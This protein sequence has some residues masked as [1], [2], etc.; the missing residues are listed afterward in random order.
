MFLIYPLVLVLSK[1]LG[2]KYKPDVPQM[3]APAPAAANQQ[4]MVTVSHTVTN[5]GANA[6][7]SP[8]TSSVAYYNG[9]GGGGG[10]YSSDPQFQEAYEAGGVFSSV[11]ESVS[12]SEAAP[13]KPP[14]HVGDQDSDS[15]SDSGTP[16]IPNNNNNNNTPGA[17]NSFV[18]GLDFSHVQM[19]YS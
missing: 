18:P 17:R 2:R 13:A 5:P 12:I 1:K 11:P 14:K 15:D 19:N 8:G 7:Y 16:Y 10:A 9:G 4:M 3:D 6:Y